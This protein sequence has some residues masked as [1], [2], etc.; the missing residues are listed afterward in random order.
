M[1]MAAMQTSEFGVTLSLNV[2]FVFKSITPLIRQLFLYERNIPA[3]QT[4]SY[5]HTNSSAT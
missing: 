1:N 3:W 2:L 5:R 4:L